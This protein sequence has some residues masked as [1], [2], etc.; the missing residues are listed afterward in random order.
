MRTVVA[1]AAGRVRPRSVQGQ[2]LMSAVRPLGRPGWQVLGK[3][4]RLGFTFEADPRVFHFGD[5]V[6]GGRRD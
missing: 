1:A 2:R 5:V 3:A 4:G 6:S